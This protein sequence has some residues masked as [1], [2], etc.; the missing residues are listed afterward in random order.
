MAPI[1]DEK[2]KEVTIGER[3]PHNAPVTLCEYDPNWPVMFQQE[4]SRIRSALG[5]KVLLLEHVGSTSV[6]GLIAK[7]KI[8]I[9]LVVEDSA[10]ES[11]YVP[12][13]EKVGYILRI[14]E[15]DWFEHRLFHGPDINVNVHVFSS[16]CSEIHRMLTFRDRLRTNAQDRDLYARTKQDLAKKTW[17]Y[18]QNY[19]DAKSEV[20]KQILSHIKSSD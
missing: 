7:P 8:D 2:L 11:S 10:N 6:P 15:P 20:V 12:F 4:A 19:A 13:L 14:R 5:D 16:G 17:K 9:L 3:L 1:D 18:V